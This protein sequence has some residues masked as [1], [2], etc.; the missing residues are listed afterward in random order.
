VATLIATDKGKEMNTSLW[1]GGSLHSFRKADWDSPAFIFLR[2]RLNNL[3]AL[4][5]ENEL[6]YDSAICESSY[7]SPEE[8]QAYDYCMNKDAELWEQIQ[9]CEF[10]I[11][12]SFE[13]E[14][15]T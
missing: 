3:I 2:E 11:V 10:A 4:I 5:E 9:D 15:L 7:S 12:R 6:K 14:R 8:K 1:L 13:Y